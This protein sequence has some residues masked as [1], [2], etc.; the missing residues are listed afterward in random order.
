MPVY[1]RGLIMETTQE[2]IEQEIIDQNPISC[3]ACDSND[4]MILGILSKRVHCR[5]R[6]CG[7]DFSYLK[8]YHEN[9]ETQ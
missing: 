7:I 6:A 1:V 2:Q 5:C 8:D 9:H 4:N 3:P